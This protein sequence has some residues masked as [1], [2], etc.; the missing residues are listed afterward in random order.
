MVGGYLFVAKCWKPSWSQ[1]RRDRGVGGRVGKLFL[2]ES[3]QCQGPGVGRNWVHGWTTAQEASES[4]C[5]GGMSS[6]VVLGKPVQRVLSLF[7][8]WWE[9]IGCLKQRSNTII[10]FSFQIA[11]SDHRRRRWSRVGKGGSRQCRRETRSLAPITWMVEMEK[12]RGRAL[13]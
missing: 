11:H 10:S 6:H 7:S 13:P 12:E 9:A 4:R 8:A 5:Q 2:A 3:H 1:V